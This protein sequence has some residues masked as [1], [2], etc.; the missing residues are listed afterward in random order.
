MNIA[1]MHTE[2]RLL[3]DKADGGSSPSFLSTEIDIFLNAAIEK[4]VSKRAFGNNAR[5]TSLEED[6][7]RRDDL[8]NLI[9]NHV[10]TTFTSNTS[11]KKNGVFVKLPTDYR[12]A[13]HEECTLKSNTKETVSVKPITYDRYNKI[14]KDPFNSPDNKTVLRLDFEKNVF[15]IISKDTLVAYYLRYLKNPSTVSLIDGVSCDLA[16]HTHREIVRM[17]VVEALENISDPRYQSSK[18]ELNEIE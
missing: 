1:S 9:S 14:I 8:R 2:F 6:Q 3:M 15:E 17:A 4:F 5:R 18:I 13:I 7:K 11:N 10:V 16:T 12:H